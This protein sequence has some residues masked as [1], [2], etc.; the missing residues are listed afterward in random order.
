MCIR[1]RGKPGIVE[2]IE[3][4]T[5][6]FKGNFPESARVDAGFCDSRSADLEAQS[7]DWGALLPRTKLSAD[8]IHVFE[9]A[10]IKL[11]KPVTHVKLNIFP[12]GG[13]SRF[14]VFGRGV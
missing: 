3:I 13:V 8:H 5:A 12:D 2:R 4:D 14:R 1:D 7:A 10:D 9:K 11:D 6:H